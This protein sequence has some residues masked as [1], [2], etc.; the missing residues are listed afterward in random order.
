MKKILL[1]NLIPILLCVIA[2]VQIYMVFTK[3]LTPWKGGGFG[4]FAMID[5]LENRPVHV[6]L[7]SSGEEYIV[8][9]RDLLK[10]E[11]YYRVKSL[12]GKDVLD[13]L[14]TDVLDQRWIIRQDVDEIERYSYLRPYSSS[15]LKPL[16]DAITADSVMVQV[17][18]IKMNIENNE[19]TLKSINQFQKVNSISMLKKS[20]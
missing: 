14:T 5:R 19:I 6:T 17:Y 11:E 4:M 10:N 7:W 18:G 9:P 16:Q 1:K 20:P 13:R 12:P 8:N 15:E 3:N 2:I